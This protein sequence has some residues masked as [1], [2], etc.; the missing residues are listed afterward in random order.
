MVK[1]ICEAFSGVP[2]VKGVAGLV[3]QIVEVADVSGH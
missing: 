1:D 2:Y 3:Q